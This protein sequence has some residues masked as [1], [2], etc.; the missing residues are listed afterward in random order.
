MHREDAEGD[1][2][3]KIA[4]QGHY[5]GRTKPTSTRQGLYVA[6]P[7]GQLLASVNST[8]AV[9]VLGMMRKAIAKYKFSFNEKIDEVDLQLNP[10]RNFNIPFP[11]GGMILRVTCRDLPRKHDPDFDTW[12]HNFDYA[13]LT[14]T[15]VQSLLPPNR[16]SS[17]SGKVYEIP[18]KTIVRFAR[19]H[20]IDH[21]KGEAPGWNSGSVKQAVAAARVTSQTDQ[22]IEIELKG[23][24]KCVQ[25][26]DG[27]INEYSGQINNTE[28]G[29]D[30]KLMGWLTWNISDKTFTKFNCVAYGNRWGTSTYNM[31]H[32]DREKNP[33]G[34]AIERLPAQPENLIEPKFL[35]YHY[36]R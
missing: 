21:V 4:E 2:M 1:F 3:R 29:V 20:L 15:E 16:Q 13:W 33:I 17:Q 9:Q 35:P 6:M 26:P 10:D 11:E 8:R 14:A 18:S 28:Q 30:L 22:E 27:R 19:N 31:R 7:D 24:V 12:L 36:F 25:T 32:Q 5:A 23:R 34:F